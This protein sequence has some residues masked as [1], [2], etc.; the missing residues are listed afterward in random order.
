MTMRAKVIEQMK[1][2]A[3][4]IQEAGKEIER[5]LTAADDSNA[6]PLPN[7]HRT[8]FTVDCA[9]LGL[10]HEIKTLRHLATPSAT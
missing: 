8:M 3:I 7:F 4:A 2:K 1:A 10:R 6:E 9:M 5:L